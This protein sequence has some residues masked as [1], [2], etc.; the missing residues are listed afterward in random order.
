LRNNGGKC[1]PKQWNWEGIK[2]G[3]PIL[4]VMMKQAGYRT[5]HV[6]K[7]HLGPQ[8]SPAADPT[9]V[10]FDINVAGDCWGHPKSFYG[11]DHYG[12]HPKYLHK[13]GGGAVNHSVPHLEKYHGTETYLTEALTREACALIRQSVLD[14]QPFFLHFS[15][16]AV[17]APFQV[18]PRFEKHYVNKG[19]SKGQVA[20]ATMVEGMDKSLGD[21]M[22]TLEALKVSEDTLIIFLGD[23]GSDAPMGATYGIGSSAPL[24]GKKGTQYEGGMRVPFIA[25]WVKPN[26]KNPWQQKLSIRSG[27][28]QTQ[29]ATIMDI[30]PTILELLDVPALKEHVVDG[31]SLKKL[32]SGH[33]D[34]DHPRSFLMH[35]PHEHRNEYFTTFRNQDWKLIYNYGLKGS[36]KIDFSPQAYELY[37]LKDDPSEQFNLAQERPERLREMVKAMVKQLEKEEALYPELNGQELRPRVP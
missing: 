36:R 1:G 24:R 21:V 32:F 16:F 7:A 22:D 6:G 34:D 26:D 12:N 11:Q 28:I 8:S 35:H 27:F 20:F 3:D 19:K 9:K 30:Y 29:M 17:H 4:P 10:G 31:H 15:H 2:V 23:N 37:H 18:D 13:D 25:S 5:L 33:P 14:E